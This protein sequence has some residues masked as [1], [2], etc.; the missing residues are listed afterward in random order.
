[1]VLIVTVPG[2]FMRGRH[3]YAYLKRIN[4]TETVAQSVDE[5]VHLA[6]RLALDEAWREKVLSKQAANLHRLYDDLDC[7]FA[8]EKFYQS[9]VAEA[10]AS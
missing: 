10:H 4:V 6:V 5:Y 1:M 3:S 7:V 9:W 8:L 2:Q